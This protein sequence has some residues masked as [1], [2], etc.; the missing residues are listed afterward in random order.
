V[1]FTFRE[2]CPPEDGDGPNPERALALRR[3]LR[4]EAADVIVAVR[5]IDE[6][7]TL[8]LTVTRSVL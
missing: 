5:R 3:E 1:P 7:P 8:D 2:P 6:H 4:V